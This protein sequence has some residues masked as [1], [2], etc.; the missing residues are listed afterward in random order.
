[1]FARLWPPRLQTHVRVFRPTGCRMA[2]EA[3]I[4]KATVAKIFVGQL[5]DRRIVGQN[6]GQVERRELFVVEGARHV[7]QRHARAAKR[8]DRSGVV[9]HRQH[10]VDR[11]RADCFLP[12]DR[13]HRGHYKFP[14]SGAI[15]E[16]H[17]P[18]QNIPPVRTH[19][20]HLNSN[21]Q[22]TGASYHMTQNRK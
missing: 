21:S 16:L 5:A 13:I 20:I 22:H 17:D 1:M 10:A 4:A 19:Q 18:A 6:A 8:A 3:E 2:A 12:P 15:G 7:E 14:I 11:A 9:D